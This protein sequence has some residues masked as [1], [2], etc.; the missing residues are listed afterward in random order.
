MMITSAMLMLGGCA[1]EPVGNESSKD[2]VGTPDKEPVEITMKTVVIDA[3]MAKNSGDPKAVVDSEGA[4]RW[5]E[6][7]AIAVNV[8]YDDVN[9]DKVNRFY[10]FTM[11]EI[12]SDND[13]VAK[14]EGEIPETGVISGVAVYPYDAKHVFAGGG[15]LKVNFPEEVSEVNH[16]P[17]MYA[18]INEGE[19]IQFEH[20]S[21]MVKVTYHCVPTGTDGFK[22][23]SDAVAGLYELDLE[24]GALTA[25]AE[26]TDQVSV[27]FNALS[28]FYAEK[29]VF[30]PVPAGEREIAV[31]LYKGEELVKWSDFSSKNVREYAAGHVAL[32]PAIDVHFSELYV[33]GDA[34]DMAGWNTSKTVLMNEPEDHVF[35]WTGEIAAGNKFRFPLLKYWWPA[36]YDNGN[37]TGEIVFTDPAKPTDEPKPKRTDF[38]VDKDGIYTITVNTVD[39]NNVTVDIHL[40]EEIT[41]YP[42]MYVVG[43]ATDWG[44]S[45]NPTANMW[46]T[47]TENGVF[48]WE[49]HLSSSGTFKFYLE[50]DH[51]PSYNKDL[52]A[53]DGVTLVYR[54]SYDDP[55]G[56][57]SVGKSGVYRVTANLNTMK[58]STELLQE[59][60]YQ[61][62]YAIGSAF[63]WGWTLSKAE[64]LS[65]EGNGVYTWT[66]NIKADGEFKFLLQKDWGAHYGPKAGGELKMDGTAE[67]HNTGDYKWVLQTSAGYESGVYKIV[68]D[69]TEGT[70][71]ATMQ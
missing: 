34:A 68:L 1:K 40:D 52:N 66:G 38:S 25:T 30:V 65:Y 61:K 46:M 5:T 51:K 67:L 12:A 62:L 29:S 71:T 69:T 55:D 27:K 16:L 49:G 18:K 37:G 11:K 44:Y 54:A 57:F 23:T 14:F 36:I 56:Q 22:L 45:I 19:D 17:M 10:E 21:S 24:T 7:D 31:G 42:D 41:V 43:S 53:A 60:E 6:D 13:N 63:D 33:I 9:G 39:M 47:Q 32:L 2:P 15:S 59:D 8:V 35:T 58:I 50:K 26:V 3:A 48:V 64:E 70:I 28:T 20:L 4:F